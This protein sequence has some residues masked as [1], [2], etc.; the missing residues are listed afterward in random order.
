MN[1]LFFSIL[2]ILPYLLFGQELKDTTL[3][4]DSVN[5][6]VPKLS[7]NDTLNSHTSLNPIFVL[8]KSELNKQTNPQLANVVGRLPSVTLKDYG[9]IGGL[10]TISVRSLGASHTKVILDGAPVINTE[11][12]QIDLGKIPLENISTLALIN[13]Q[14]NKPLQTAQAYAGGSVLNISTASKLKNKRELQLNLQQGSFGL[15]RGS[16]LYKK[17]FNKKSKFH[18]YHL[19]QNAEGSY[20]F[21][22]Q[23]GEVTTNE[24]RNNADI[25][26]HQHI[27][28]YYYENTKQLKIHSKA[29]YNHTERGLPGAVTLYNP[30]TGERLWEHNAFVQNIINYKKKK[31]E[32]K[33]VS[34]YNYSW[35]RYKDPHF[36]NENS[37]IE[38]DYEQQS[39]FNSIALKYP[40]KNKWN[41]FYS[42][43]YEYSW[44]W[45]NT[46]NH[47]Q[48]NRNSLLN[49]L[50][51]NYQHK[52]WRIEGN[53]LSTFVHEKTITTDNNRNTHQLIPSI[54][55]GYKPW[56]EKNWR[57]ST[58]FKQTFR[59]P[60]F[61]DL[62]Y[63]RVGNINLR[64]EQANQWNIGISHEFKGGLLDIIQKSQFKLDAYWYEVKDKIVAIPTR[65]LFV[66][67]M[68]N[69]GKVRTQGFEIYAQVDFMKY[70]KVGIDLSTSYNLQFALD[71]TDQESSTYNN[72]IPYIPF[73]T[74]AGQ[75]NVHYSKNW[76]F[77]WAYTYTGHRFYLPEN[78]HENV[79]PS[80][81]LHDLSIQYRFNFKKQKLRTK[82]DIN[83]I[84]NRDYQVIVYYPMPKISYRLSLTLLL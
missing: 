39:I 84:F 46:P 31:L 11:T 54:S 50:G 10:K 28:D 30:S 41:L 58:S 13:Q 14:W 15:G 19:V 23:N 64:P 47:A 32:G 80:W 7:I 48:P 81:I 2:S 22:L 25:F 51:S 16:I 77:S 82:L 5:I 44:L 38:D 67:S 18:T 40:I 70:K 21:E 45:S 57:L 3:L 72:Q 61:N 20:P 78:I 9:G 6:Y 83:N 52:K 66:W 34:K 12:G 65:N 73:E 60:T 1:K 76:S 55:I 8:G 69:F 33:W 24:R 75:I 26:Q 36:L 49:V 79:L 29:F 35:K 59:Y 4:I 62:Y 37:M 27:I 42:T 74:S 17:K 68:Q 71:R 63:V 53:I 43:D 56:W